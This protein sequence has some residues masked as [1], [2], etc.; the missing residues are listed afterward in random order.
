MSLKAKTN[1]NDDS[2]MPHT[3]MIEGPQT[4]QRFEDTMNALFSKRKSEVLPEKLGYD[5]RPKNDQPLRSAFYDAI[6][7]DLGDAARPGLLHDELQFTAHDIEH[8][9]HPRLAEG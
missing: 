5:P 3:E 4:L 8:L 9:L 2:L 7:C 6:P 1:C